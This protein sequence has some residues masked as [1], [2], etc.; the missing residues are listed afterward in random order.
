M[1]ATEETTEDRI[2]APLT[3]P[4][5]PKRRVQG[6]ILVILALAFVPDLFNSVAALA[7]PTASWGSFAMRALALIIRSLSIC[8]VLIYILRL[9]GDGMRSV[10]LWRPHIFVDVALGVVAFFTW[11]MLYDQTVVIVWQLEALGAIP[12]A[13]IDVGVSERVLPVGVWGFVWL[14]LMSGAN[15]FAEELV[16]RGYLITRLRHTLG[17]T[18][19]AIVISTALFASYHAYQGVLGVYSAALIGAILGIVFVMTNRLWPCIVAHTI[20]N[21]AAY[22]LP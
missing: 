14:V 20:A 9:N 18:F 5:G 1:E 2:F 13:W 6:E 21:V 22:V 16:M 12:M 8:A 3:P 17:S 10:G 4:T 15:G 11:R 7:E 19:G